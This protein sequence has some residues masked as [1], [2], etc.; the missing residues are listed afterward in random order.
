[1]DQGGVD[2]FDVTVER[3][4]TPYGDHDGEERTE[5]IETHYDPSD[6]VFC[7]NPESPEYSGSQEPPS[8]EYRPF[9]QREQDV[10]DDAR[11]EAERELR[12]DEQADAEAQEE[13]G[14][15]EGTP[16]SSAEPEP[17]GFS[18]PQPSGSASGD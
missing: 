3:I 11:A 8:D 9:S 15:P 16:S 14:R 7:T 13:D 10:K 12:E 5:V 1:M 6:E 17:S 4:L 2:G 18:T